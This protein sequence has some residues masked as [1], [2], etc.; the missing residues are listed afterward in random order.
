MPEVDPLEECRTRLSHWAKTGELRGGPGSGLHPGQVMGHPFYGN[1]A[2]PA[3]TSGGGVAAAQGNLAGMSGVAFERPDGPVTDTERLAAA[4]DELGPDEDL[5]LCEFEDNHTP[6]GG[7]GTDLFC[8][9]EGAPAQSRLPKLR[10]VPRPGTKA[11]K[12]K[13]AA[14]AAV[15]GAEIVD[16]GPHFLAHLKATAKVESVTVP[17]NQLRP[18]QARLSGYKVRLMRQ[19]MKGAAFKP[20]PVLVS[21][22]H[23]VVDGHHRWV[24]AIANGEKAIAVERVNQPILKVLKAEQVWAEAFGLEQAF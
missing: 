20:A 17:T 1:A 24:S 12:L 13:P 19:A 4:I 6:S 21:D 14:R 2:G 9:V 5:D 16:L 8:S 3:S 10:G 15:T 11:A 23:Y 18:T 7:Q 22:E